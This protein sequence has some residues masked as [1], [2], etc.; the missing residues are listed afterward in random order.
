MVKVA[1]LCG[2]LYTQSIA[3][4]NVS[5]ATL[6]YRDNSLCTRQESVSVF[7]RANGVNHMYVDGSLPGHP[8]ERDGVIDWYVREEIGDLQLGRRY[9]SCRKD[10]DCMMKKMIDFVQP[11]TS[12]PRNVQSYFTK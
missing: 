6:S 7:Y 10:G 12:V 2:S 1:G 8:A 11:V 3:I 4:P 5:H 9:I